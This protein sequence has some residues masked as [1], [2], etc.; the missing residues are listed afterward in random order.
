MSMSSLSIPKRHHKSRSLLSVLSLSALLSPFLSVVPAQAA[1]I[2]AQSSAR[3]AK[4]KPAARPIGAG[5][6]A[7]VYRLAPDDVIS[8]VVARHPEYSV[9]Q[10]T[11]PASGRVQLPLVGEIRVSGKTIGEAQLLA[12][13]L[14]LRKL[15]R[16]QVAVSLRQARAQRVSVLGDT[17]AN[18]GIYEVRFG[19]RVSD[20]LASAGG[21]KDLPAI[22][23][24][25]LSRADGQKIPLNIEQI[26]GGGNVAFDFLLRGG[27][28]LLF[29]ARTIKVGVLGQVVK[30]ANY[31]LPI[32]SRV[33]DA[34][35]QAG[36]ATNRAA[37]TK[38]TLK[39]ADGSTRTLNLLAVLQNAV[40]G[41]VSL[42]PGSVSSPFSSASL[43]VADN[44]VLESGD[45][46]SVPESQA[47]IS[48]SGG[49]IRT[50]GLYDL[51]DGRVSRISDVVLQA[52]DLSVRPELARF[53]LMR[54][55]A[56]GTP[57]E[58]PNV[59]G[60]TLVQ[61]GDL[62][63]VEAIKI[64]NVSITG[65]VK[66]PGSY[67]LQPGEGLP[68]LVTRAGGATEIAALTR[69]IVKRGQENVTLNTFPA[70]TQGK[71]LDFPLQD[72]DFVVVPKNPNRVFVM[73]AV[74]RPGYYP[75]PETGVL[76]LGEAISNAGGTRERAKVRQ[77]GLIRQTPSGVKRTIVS[78]DGSG[79]DQL[80]VNLPLQ[81]NDIVY[82]PEGTVKRNVL[83]QILSVL[84]IVNILTGY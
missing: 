8:I 63:S 53:H 60:D 5:V 65:E 26:L 58:V 36:G 38:A 9:E 15:L 62:V 29:H 6:Q 21:L 72:G 71:P 43:G 20:A 16:P 32:G 46:I 41:N 37:L 50:P 14:L 59:N 84:P 22:V 47:R 54:P 7:G 23:E 73:Q 30:P 51:P 27:D 45:I 24:G 2:K 77:I 82:V 13:Q 3:A 10:I 39:H 4:S 56:N 18:P 68:E 25:T 66:V 1:P 17:V 83:G 52:G 70:L 76:T 80:A 31:E 57:S 69:V 74:V 42:S 64:P 81:A 19:W 78:L 34:L 28:T 33:A 55:D 61:D 12:R 75:I 44:V 79:K 67:Q 49:G 48:V 35:T 11:I 40:A